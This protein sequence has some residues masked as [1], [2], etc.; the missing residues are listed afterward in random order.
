[1]ASRGGGAAAGRV[2]LVALAGLVGTACS[3]GQPRE[4]LPPSAATVQVRLLDDELVHDE[5]VP[6]GRVVFRVENAGDAVHRVALLPLPDDAVPLDEELANDT[7]QSVELIARVG[8]LQPDERG[9]FAVD[10]ATGQR[11]ALVDFSKAADGTSHAR[12]GV[13]AEFRTHADAAPSSQ[14]TATQPPDDPA[15]SS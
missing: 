8:G 2:L 4:P 12:L 11:Y 9:V 10:L 15:D 5:P 6:A 3:G 13:A 14:P 1:M 7:P